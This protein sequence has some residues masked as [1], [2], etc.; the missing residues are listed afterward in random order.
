[1]KRHQN[2]R[3]VIGYS[4]SIPA[5]DPLQDGTRRRDGYCFEPARPASGA[6]AVV[7]SARCN[8]VNSGQL[9]YT[10]VHAK[11]RSAGVTWHGSEIPKFLTNVVRDGR[12]PRTVA[13]AR[14]GR[15]AR[16]LG[17]GVSDY[18]QEFGPGYGSDGF[19]S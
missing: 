18:Y 3:S 19:R 7:L 13:G 15:L 9:R 17:S 1:M 2:S 12:G 6:P 4:T 16:C 11:R 8:E 5:P 14:F 10:T